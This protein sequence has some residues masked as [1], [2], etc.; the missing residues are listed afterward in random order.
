M[1]FETTKRAPEKILIYGNGKV[2]KSFCWLDIAEWMYRKKPAVNHPVM[3]LIDID[4]TWDKA[5]DNGY[6]ELEKGGFV[7]P[8]QPSDF[9]SMMDVSREVRVKASHGDWIVID[10]VEYPWEKAQHY[11]IQ[12]VMGDEPENYFLEMRKEVKK[13]EADDKGHKA[14]FGGHEGM[15]WIFITKVYKQFEIPL[16]MESRAHV[17][18]VTG[19]KQLNVNRGATV[20][21]IKQTKH[22]GKMWPAGQK[23]ILHRHDTIMRMTRRANGQRQLTMIGDRN[24]ER[25]WEEKMGSRTLN[26]DDDPAHKRAFAK[27]YLKDIAGWRVTK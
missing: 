1:P 9:P 22:A 5:Y 18:S 12:S 7:I 6:A 23:G 14:Q 8:Y 20:D 16:T 25:I 21:Q 17:M 26:I 10:M 15:D 3:Y 24:R 2:G 4:R 27:R 13:A 19:E 11:Y